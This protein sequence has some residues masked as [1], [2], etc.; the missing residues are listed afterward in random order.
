MQYARNVAINKQIKM[1]DP[2]IFEASRRYPFHH[3]A[4]NNIYKFLQLLDSSNNV[5]A[6]L[7]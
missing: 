4:R 3:D 7:S 5:N 2:I 6:E 1:C